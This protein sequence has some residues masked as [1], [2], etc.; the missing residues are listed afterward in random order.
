MSSISKWYKWYYDKST[1]VIRRYRFVNG[2]KKWEFYS[3]KKWKH[4]SE[5]ERDALIKRLNVSF[6]VEK[7]KAEERYN[8]DHAFIN[9]KT[10]EEFEQYIRTQAVDE[11]YIKAFMYSI[12]E[13]TLKY[14]VYSAKNPDPNQWKKDQIGFGKFLLAK[15]ISASYIKRII[16]NTNRLIEFLHNKWPDEVRLTVLSPVAELVLNER[17]KKSPNKT[18]KKYIDELAFADMCEKIDKRL[19]PFIKMSY[20]FGLRVSEALGLRTEDVLEDC[21]FI[22]RQLVSITPTIKTKPPKGGKLRDVP[23][24]F[25]TPEEAYNLITQLP[26]AHSD[27]I[28]HLFALEME[29]LNLPFKT[30]DFRRS[31][32]TRACRIYSLRDAQLAAG[33]SDSRTTEDY[34]QDDRLFNRKKFV[35]KLTLVKT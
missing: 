25:C 12:H 35:P 5:D 7:K 18:R 31:F 2:K 3:A 11:E 14:F 17:E 6:E 4:L 29:R 28:K 34:S 32:I 13:Y 26:V 20:F 15:E 16:F 23:Y 9:V 19:V 30:H 1:N 21:L 27:T 33:H 22:Q 10:I 24:W 8:Y